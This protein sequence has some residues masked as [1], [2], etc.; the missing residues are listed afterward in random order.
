MKVR[1]LNTLNIHWALPFPDFSAIS[2]LSQKYACIWSKS[3]PRMAVKGSPAVE[4]AECAETCSLAEDQT[5]AMYF[6]QLC[7]C[8]PP[9]NLHSPHWFLGFRQSLMLC[10]SSPQLKHL[11][12]RGAGPF[13]LLFFFLSSH[14]RAPM[15]SAS[16][17]GPNPISAVSAWLR[18]LLGLASCPAHAYMQYAS[19]LEPISFMAMSV[20]S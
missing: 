6:E 2:F 8:P 14:E 7:L 16:G 17:P 12:L 19:R 10:P 13:P 15:S 20:A 5:L 4:G 9:W 11:L 1:L 18:V 3:M